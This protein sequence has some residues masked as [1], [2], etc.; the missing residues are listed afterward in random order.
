MDLD[1]YLP[2]DGETLDIVAGDILSE[3]YHDDEYKASNK[4]KTSVIDYVTN[5]SIS[6][7]YLRVLTSNVSS[8]E[9]HFNMTWKWMTSTGRASSP[10]HTSLF[11]LQ[12]WPL[13]RVGR[14]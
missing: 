11:R 8:E 7:Q 6:I 10:P 2:Q 5:S 14:A 9:S 4:T 1:H 13:P 3:H 12:L